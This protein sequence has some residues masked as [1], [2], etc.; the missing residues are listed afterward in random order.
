MKMAHIAVY[1]KLQI[2]AR[3]R[4]GE[5]RPTGQPSRIVAEVWNPI[6][7]AIVAVTDSEAP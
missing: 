2:G 3:A 7:V 5:A 1:R 4:E 6:V